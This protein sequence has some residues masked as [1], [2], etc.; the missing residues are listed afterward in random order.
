MKPAIKYHLK[1]TFSDNNYNTDS[2]N[3]DA[4]E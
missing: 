2:D 3:M 4:T 1:K